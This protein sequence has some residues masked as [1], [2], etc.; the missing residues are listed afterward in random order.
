MEI[1]RERKDVH[2]PEQ[3]SHIVINFV[4]RALLG[5]AM[6]FFIND[7]LAAKDISLSVGMNPLTVATSGVFG[8]PGVA[9]LY[10]IAFYQGI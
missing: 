6:I 1:G 9:L 7:F 8:A 10:G 3:R 2:M 4:V 5:A